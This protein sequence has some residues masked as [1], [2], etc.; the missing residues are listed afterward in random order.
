MINSYFNNFKMMF[1]C[2]KPNII[3]S[4]TLLILM[5][6][7]L[8][9]GPAI[10]DIFLSLIALNF[11]IVSIKNK[12]WK[13]YQNPVVIGFLIFSVYGIL[14]S[15]FSDM[16]IS[17]LTNEG[18]VFYFRYIFFAMGVWYLLDNNPYL[19]KCFLVTLSFCLILVSLDGIVQYLI[20]VDFFGNKQITIY[21]ISGLFGDEPIL[22]RYVVYLMMLLF[23]IFYQNS[24][25][26]KKNIIISLFFLIISEIIIFLSG[27][28][29]PLFYAIFFSLLIIFFIPNY[30]L[31]RIAG[32]I[33]SFLIIFGILQIN[34]NAK[35]RMIT[36]TIK[37][38]SSTSIP[39]LPYNKGY[40]LHYEAALL[41]FKDSPVF[42]VGTNTYRF[43]SQKDKYNPNKND[44][45]SHPHQYY[46]QVLSELG[47]VGFLF[48]ALFYLYLVSIA[49][50]YLYLSLISN[51]INNLSFD[52]L[53]FVLV[54]LVFWWPIIPHMSFYNNWTNVLVMLPLGYFFKNIYGYETTKIK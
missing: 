48:L 24:T 19:D 12:L 41:M 37:E 40:E 38:M 47:I 2:V 36:Q 31:Y 17:S 35:D 34:P 10:P 5:P 14:R 27:E 54:L 28:R 53:L 9:S 49:F 11:L 1:S 32:V 45:N 20:G 7:A 15:I 8:I 22:G 3:F 18:S 25:K 23:A 6:I 46:L 21:R 51:K 39:I 30:R 52:Q 29:V 50:K 42:G 26:T 43:Q 33:I 4:S 44:I 16:P 13:Y